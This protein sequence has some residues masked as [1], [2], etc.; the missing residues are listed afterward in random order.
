[1]NL[2]TSGHTLY[3]PSL[4]LYCDRTTGMREAVQTYVYETTGIDVY[5]HPYTHWFDGTTEA[6]KIATIRELQQRAA[7]AP[8]GTAPQYFILLGIDHAT[9]PAQNALLKLLEEPPAQ[10]Q[11]ILCAHSATGVL[12][13]IQ[14]RCHN[15]QLPSPVQTSEPT[16][17]EQVGELYNNL[18]AA[19]IGT[20]IELAEQYKDRSEA[21]H[22]TTSLI[23]FLHHQ[24]SQ[25][26]KQPQII[27]HIKI[28]LTLKQQLERNCNPQLVVEEAF[29]HLST[30]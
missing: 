15:V 8:V 21:Q 16:H 1:M 9:I 17:L 11:V 28:L 7:Y 6:L 19:T 20:K 29:F 10:T 23:Q 30:K 24:L 27:D 5:T 25:N 4:L 26:P 14:S 3:A 18:L 2:H 13:T 12:P 22:L